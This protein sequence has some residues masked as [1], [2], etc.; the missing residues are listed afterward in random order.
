MH[1]RR[2]LTVAVA[3]AAVA[4]T[5]VLVAPVASATPSGGDDRVADAPLVTRDTLLRPASPRTLE[6][7]ATSLRAARRPLFAFWG[8]KYNR[9]DGFTFQAAVR[10]SGTGIQLGVAW[11]TYRGVRPI[12]PKKVF[13]QSRVDGGTWTTVPGARGRIRKSGFV[14]AAVPAHVVP[15]GVPVQTV[16]YRLKT[17]RITSGPR[18]ARRSI[19]SDPVSVRFENQSMYTGD[20]ARFYAPIKDLCPSASITLDTGHTIAQKRD[21][22]FDFQYGIAIDVAEINAVTSETEAS[23]LAVAIHECAHWRQFYNWGGTLKGFRAMEKRSGE[24]F[25]A[26]T[27]PSGPTAPMQPDW[28]PL[29]HAADCATFL[30]TSGAQRTYGGWCNP[31]ESAAAGL[32]WQGQKY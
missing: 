19:V 18:K 12:L 2:R 30:V 6:P 25:V 29:E 17:K 13:V 10:G 31:T 11:K 21:A 16:D 14:L 22:V 15:A 27:N 3:A 23:K 20:Q 9:I 7:R 26:D 1:V 8:Q 5:P 24:V 28:A 4:L 32:L